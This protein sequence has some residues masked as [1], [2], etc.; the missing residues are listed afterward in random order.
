[1]V[2]SERNMELMFLE[3]WMSKLGN[4]YYS[5]VGLCLAYDYYLA[6]NCNL[7]SRIVSHWGDSF[8]SRFGVSYPFNFNHY[9]YNRECKQGKIQEN[10]KRIDW[11]TNRIKELKR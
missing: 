9:A 7:S 4:T 3:D 2:I 8:S 5:R 1:M 6:K 11:V 10:A